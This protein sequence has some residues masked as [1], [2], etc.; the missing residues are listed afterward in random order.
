MGYELE[1]RRVNSPS[2]AHIIYDEVA[3]PSLQLRYV[4]YGGG[5][6]ANEPSEPLGS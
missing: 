2:T 3:R 4:F 5:R 6:L 1:K